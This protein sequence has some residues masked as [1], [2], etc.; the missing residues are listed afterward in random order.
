MKDLMFLGMPWQFAAAFVLFLSLAV[1]A[2]IYAAKVIAYFS[3]NAIISNDTWVPSQDDM[4]RKANA[5]IL[6][7][8]AKFAVYGV[9]MIYLTAVKDIFS[10]SGAEILKMLACWYL[11]A[12]IGLYLLAFIIAQVITKNYIKQQLK[13]R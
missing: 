7:R 9:I 6:L 12:I 4:R 11:P 2:I 3:Y 5:N 13:K 1:I 10:L 8:A